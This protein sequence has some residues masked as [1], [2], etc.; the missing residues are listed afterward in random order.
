MKKLRRMRIE[1][2]YRVLQ[3]T[4]LSH[5]RDFYYFTYFTLPYFALLYLTYL[6]Y[7]SL[8]L[9]IIYDYFFHFP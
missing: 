4:F 2:I 9:F 5:E 3:L 8:F 1:G 7:Y 6:R